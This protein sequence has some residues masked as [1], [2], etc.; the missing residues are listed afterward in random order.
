MTAGIGKRVVALAEEWVGTPYRHQASLKGVGCD[1]LGLIRGIWREIYGCEPEAPPAY[2]PDWAERGG[3]ERLLS[4]AGR[5]FL[6]VVS[7]DA[8]LPG[9]V[10]VFRWR[11]GCAAKHVG[12]LCRGGR[13]TH[14]YEQA[15]VIRSPLVP[16]WRRK[17]VAVFRFPA[18]GG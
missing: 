15:A 16:A 5:H 7:M 10:L 18:V 14:A 9:D 8:A 4:A 6:S 12:I 2:A 1:C 11:T 3:E 17:V 13:F